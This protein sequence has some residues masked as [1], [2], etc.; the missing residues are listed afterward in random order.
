[1]PST[2]PATARRPASPTRPTALGRALASLLGATLALTAPRAAIAQEAARRDAARLVAAGDSAYA[3]HDAAGALQRYLAAIAAAPSAVEPLARA[4]HV[5]TELAEF[6]TGDAHAR[7]LLADAE[8]HARAAVASAPNDPRA[9]FVLAEALGR[10][11]L[12][13]P[14]LRRLPYATEVHDQAQRCLDL[15]AKDAACLHVLG[16]WAAEY[17]RL[18]AYTREMADAMSGGKLFTGATWAAAEEKLA[19]AVGIEPDRVIHRYDLA[20]VYRDEGKR[21]SAYAE[22]TAAARAPAR[23]Y[24]DARYQAAARA[25]LDSLAHAR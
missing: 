18:D 10:I 8:R 21:D 25:A 9:H 14:V 2:R 16:S 5:E 19:A 1:M 13:T 7:T 23:E 20:R 15:A 17:M 6:D 4:A 11:A 12:R 24:N 3:A 22:F